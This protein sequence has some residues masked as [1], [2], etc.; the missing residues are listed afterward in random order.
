M[1]PWDS[2]TNS[3]CMPAAA[4]TTPSYSPSATLR[5][6]VSRLPRIGRTWSP[7]LTFSSW[8]F[9]RSEDVPMMA[10]PGRLANA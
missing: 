1:P 7:G 4:I 8:I 3:R 6:L 2:G 9:R 10:L 5:S